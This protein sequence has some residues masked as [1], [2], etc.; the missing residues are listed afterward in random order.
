MKCETYNSWS[1]GISWKISAFSF[2]HQNRDYYNVTVTIVDDSNDDKAYL[3]HNR[4]HSGI[5]FICNHVVLLVD[6]QNV[7]GFFILIT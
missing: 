4:V 5:K 3:Y 1:H 2:G 6:L 7:D